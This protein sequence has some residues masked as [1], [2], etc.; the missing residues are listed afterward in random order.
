MVHHL[1]I[2]IIQ[3]QRLSSITSQH[4]GF[5][6]GGYERGAWSG[7][8]ASPPNIFKLVMEVIGHNLRRKI[9]QLQRL[10]WI[11][12]PWTT[13]HLPTKIIQLQRSSNMD[14]VPWSDNLPTF[15]I[16]LWMLTW[17]IGPW[18]TYHLPI[19]INQ[20]WRLTWRIWTMHHV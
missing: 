6:Y 20:L 7:G 4:F 8:D 3:I 16:Q 19:K 10:T 9:I 11:F 2:K 5:R 18:T 12:G 1:P 17:K 15:E 13:Y 14:H